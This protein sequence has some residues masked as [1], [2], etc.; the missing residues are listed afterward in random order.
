MFR[1]AVVTGEVTGRIC[2]CSW[3]SHFNQRYRRNEM[4]KKKLTRSSDAIRK[5]Y[6]EAFKETMAN[7]QL[8][9]QIERDIEKY[10]RHLMELM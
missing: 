9:N 5:Q 2:N 1:V 8:L 6:Q 7:E 4:E 3:S 10:E